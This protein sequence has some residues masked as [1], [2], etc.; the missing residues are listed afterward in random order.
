MCKI[1]NASQ[2]KSKSHENCHTHAR[3]KLRT[4]LIES[5]GA[6]QL[7][8]I[9]WLTR[10]K[11]II[12]IIYESQMT[13]TPKNCLAKITERDTIYAINFVYLKIPSNTMLCGTMTAQILDY[14]R[15]DSKRHFIL[16]YCFWLWH[17]SYFS[18]VQQRI[19][20]TRM[21]S[22]IGQLFTIICTRSFRR[23][24]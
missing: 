1:F 16:K 4:V 24:T 14:H 23:L 22:K 7:L 12:F 5:V 15:N 21:P 13:T 8:T 6:K 19:T 10:V 2:R 9:S 17:S 11:R 18:L 3:T 20:I